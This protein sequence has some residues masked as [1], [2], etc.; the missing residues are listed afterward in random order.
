MRLPI[1]KRMAMFRTDLGATPALHTFDVFEQ[2]GLRVGKT[3]R[4]M[5][6]AATQGTSLQKKR[7]PDSRAIVSGKILDRCEDSVPHAS[8]PSLSRIKLSCIS[9]ERSENRAFHPHTRT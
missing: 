8:R 5:T 3:F 7:A 2:D 1:R 6:P 9:L 4:I